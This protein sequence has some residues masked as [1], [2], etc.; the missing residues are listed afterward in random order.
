MLKGTHQ[1]SQPSAGTREGL[2]Q[3]LFF[4]KCDLTNR[5]SISC[6][7]TK[8]QSLSILSAAAKF[9]E[10]SDEELEDDVFED[11]KENFEV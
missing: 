4:E 10:E 3:V 8:S 5:P 1:R 6:C 9:N 11:P 2:K 7:G